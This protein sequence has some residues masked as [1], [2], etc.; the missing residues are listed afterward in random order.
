MSYIGNDFGIDVNDFLDE[1]NRELWEYV[2]SNHNIYIKEAFEDNYGVHIK[3]DEFIIYVLSNDICPASFTHELL[4]IYLSIKKYSLATYIKEVKYQNYKLLRIFSHELEEHIGNVLEHRKMM[5]IYIDMG[6]KKSEFLSDYDKY[7]MNDSILSVLI[8]KYKKF[9]FYR[10]VYDANV[11]DMY[12]G[13]YFA[14]KCCPNDSFDYK[15]YMR[16]LKLIDW[17]LFNILE[18]FVRRFD[19]TNI[20][21]DNND[22]F[23]V[24]NNFGIDMLKW[25]KRREII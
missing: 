18:V 3:E 7:K 8:S 25:V 22:L 16:M 15:I 2:C 12:I 19:E 21:D 17:Q 1:K 4:H 13:K 6:Y 20:D 24:I 11:I 9:R 5:P 23:G 14:M 10:F